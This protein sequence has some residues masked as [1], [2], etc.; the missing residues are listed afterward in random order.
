MCFSCFDIRIRVFQG[1]PCFANG[2]LPSGVPFKSCLKK[3]YDAPI[4]RDSISGFRESPSW[5]PQKDGRLGELTSLKSADLEDPSPCNVSHN[6]RNRSKTSSAHH[7]TPDTGEMGG[8][9]PF[10]N[11]SPRHFLRRVSSPKSWWSWDSF[12]HARRGPSPDRAARS[13][14]FSEHKFFASVG[15]GPRVRLGGLLGAWGQRAEVAQEK[16]LPVF[17]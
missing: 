5:V 17:S 3:G 14:G 1:L 10:Q 8:W 4:R 15:R 9:L 12:G 7:S 11:A 6:R 2:W 13:V 16:N